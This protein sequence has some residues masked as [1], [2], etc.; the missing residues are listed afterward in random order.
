MMLGLPALALAVSLSPATE[1]RSTT[2]WSASPVAV[3]GAVVLDFEIGR[4]RFGDGAP[5]GGISP[6]SR[7]EDCSDA[8]FHCLRTSYGGLV[9]PRLCSEPP[10]VGTR[11]ERHGIVTRVI[12]VLPKPLGHLVVPGNWYVLQTEGAPRVA[13][14]Y[15]SGAGV[16]EILFSPVGDLDLSWAPTAAA[17][18][19]P[20][21]RPELLR[22]R[23]P[24][25]TFRRFGQCQS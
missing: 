4:V 8:A 7:L 21:S 22:V 23:H 17:A 6:D 1:D 11:W 15:E 12:G 25:R 14:L 18:A 3:F 10:Q 2:T 16:Q 5:P 20:L 19:N 13:Y 9:L 24:L